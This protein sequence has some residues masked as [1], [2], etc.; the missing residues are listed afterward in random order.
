M[1]GDCRALVA[2]DYCDV[3]IQADTEIT[4]NNPILVGQMLLS[5]D[6]VQGDPAL[7]FLAPVT[8]YRKTYTFLVPSEYAAQHIA[9]SATANGAVLLDG[10]DVSDGLTAFGSDLR[11]GRFAMEQGRHTLEC[12]AHCGLIVVGYDEAV[13]YM[14]AGGLDLEPIRLE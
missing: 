4:S 5:T 1:T 8:Q 2:G 14:F 10:E 11:G 12:S 6:G 3:Y 9:V 7:A 13:S